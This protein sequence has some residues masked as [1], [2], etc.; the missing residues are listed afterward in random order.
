MSSSTLSARVRNPS[1]KYERNR[2]VTKIE[3]HMPQTT[4][5]HI[6]KEKE[7]QRV[8]LFSNKQHSDATRVSFEKTKSNYDDSSVVSQKPPNRYYM[9]NLER[10]F[11]NLPIEEHLIKLYRDHFLQTCQGI[12]FSKIV[13]P[14]DPKEL[15]AK[16]VYLP[17]DEKY[18]RNISPPSCSN[19]H[20]LSL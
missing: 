6:S 15:A 1:P 7:N 12:N 14:V 4:K 2:E 17:K 8:F 18:K 10:Y 5:H 11:K 16:K 20:Y 13:K 9:Y 3:A 19:S